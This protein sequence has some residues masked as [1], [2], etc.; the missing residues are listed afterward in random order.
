MKGMPCTVYRPA[1]FPDCTNGGVTSRASRVLLVGPG[2]PEVAE[3]GNLP[4]LLLDMREGWDHP[5][6]TPLARPS[7]AGNRW[8]MFGGNF[9]YTSDSR[10]PSG[11]P[12]PVHDRIED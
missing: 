9:I 8:T 2:V 11:R 10:F 1:D 3:P 7:D 5:C 6:L 12:I 4:V